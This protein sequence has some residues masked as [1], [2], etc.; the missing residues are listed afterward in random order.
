[1]I[2]IEST[3]PMYKYRGDYQILVKLERVADTNQQAGFFI[4]QFASGDNRIAL[5]PDESLTGKLD[6]DEPRSMYKVILDY[7]KDVYFTINEM[8]QKMT[9]TLGWNVYIKDE[10]FEV[11]SLYMWTEDNWRHTYKNEIS[12]FILWERVVELNSKN[13]S[14][15]SCTSIYIHG[16]K[17]KTRQNIVLL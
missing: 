3:D 15:A 12:F 13:L 4:I 6:Q 7:H 2:K 11:R 10:E 1:M 5:N 8:S 14:S 17:Q 16:K 9:K